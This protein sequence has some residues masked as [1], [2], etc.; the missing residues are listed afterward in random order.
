[1]DG[2]PDSFS[3]KRI[4]V[5]CTSGTFRTRRARHRGCTA[6]RLPP[7]PQTD[8]PRV[9]LPEFSPFHLGAGCFSDRHLDAECGTG[10]VGVPPDTFG[11]FAWDSMVLYA[12]S[13]VRAG[14]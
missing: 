6:E 7:R 4:A 1:M 12:D 2:E 13:R 10:M 5:H 8:V 14:T 11:T 3:G 9:A